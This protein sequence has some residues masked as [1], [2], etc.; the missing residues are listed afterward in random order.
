MCSNN[1]HP[2]SS[3]SNR[4]LRSFTLLR[5]LLHNQHM[6]IKATRFLKASQLN[7]N[8]AKVTII[9]VIMKVPLLQP[10]I[11]EARAKVNHLLTMVIPEMIRELHAKKSALLPHLLKRRIVKCLHLKKRTRTAI[12]ACSHSVPV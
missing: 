7:L 11:M 6:V 4:L 1:L 8:I 5:P 2:W 9:E 3:N 12:A 10:N